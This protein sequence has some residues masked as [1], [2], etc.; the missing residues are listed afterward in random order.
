MAD[1]VLINFDSTPKQRRDNRRPGGDGNGERGR[2]GDRS[3]EQGRGGHR[4]G[5]REWGGDRN[6]EK[7]RGGGRK[8]VR[9]WGG[10]RDGE[11]GRG[12]DRNG[13]RGRGSK[14]QTTGK[15]PAER[16]QRKAD[17][18]GS[19]S[20]HSKLPISDKFLKIPPEARA[21]AMVEALSQ[22]MEAARTT[23]P[24]R[25]APKELR[26]PRTAAVPFNPA[27]AE[28]MNAV[29]RQI[30]NGRSPS[31]SALSKLD[32]TGAI[33]STTSPTEAQGRRCWVQWTT[34]S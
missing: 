9:V 8:D 27:L 31:Q 7:G 11:R 18:E 34:Q 21:N 16:T 20:F 15:V 3:G 4:N 29:T 24:Q 13:E 32:I 25:P 26:K 28:A 30:E 5:E 12:G 2:G 10:D 17:N 1:G 19:Q 33:W 6:G 23:R 14:A 22:H